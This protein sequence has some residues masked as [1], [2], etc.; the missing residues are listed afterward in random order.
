MSSWNW[1][2]ASSISRSRLMNAC[3]IGSVKDVYC[4]E[5]TNVVKLDENRHA[6]YFALVLV[7]PNGHVS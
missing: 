3:T 5:G 2:S 4:D 7:P 6:V 1:G